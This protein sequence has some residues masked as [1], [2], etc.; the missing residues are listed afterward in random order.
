MIEC[1]MCGRPA[2]KRARQVYGALSC[3]K[4]WARFA[5]RRQVAWM[6]DVLIIDIVAVSLG[7]AMLSAVGSGGSGG[8]LPTSVWWAVIAAGTLYLLFKDAMFAGRSP[9]KALLGLRV[10]ELQLWRPVPG[11]RAVILW[12]QRWWP[13]WVMPATRLGRRL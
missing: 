6:L 2:G 11:V 5:S 9:G 13:W 3:R 4:C 8:R 10:V 1:A 7:L 12:L